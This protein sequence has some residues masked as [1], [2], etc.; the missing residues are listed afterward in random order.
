MSSAI[1]KANSTLSRGPVLIV[2][3]GLIGGSLGFALSKLGLDVYLE[4][5]SPTSLALAQDL[6][7]GKRYQAQLPPPRLVVVATP[8]DVSAQVVCRMLDSFPSAFVC[9]VASVKEPITRAVLATHSQHAH[10]YCPVHPMTGREIN[11]VGA[12]SADLFPGRPWVVVPTGH[13]GAE[14]KL[15][16]RNLGL[17]LDMQVSEMSPQEHDRAVALVS[18]VPQ[19]VSSLLASRLVEA[20]LSALALAGGGLRDTTRIAASDPRLWNAILS[21][22]TPAVRA[23]LE[24]LQADLAALVRSLATNNTSPLGK[25]EISPAWVGAFNRVLERGNEGRSRIP[26]KHGAS[27]ETYGTLSVLIPDTPGA[28]AKLFQDAGHARIN[29]EDLH[30][31]HSLGQ[32]QGLMTLWVVPSQVEPLREH[33]EKQGWQLVTG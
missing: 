25:E 21:Q 3:T 14:T 11:G 17:D 7:A 10:R 19:L 2:G 4:D 15:V 27:Q 26:G 31:E 6:G 13:T 33:L 16:M 20:P 8:P 1:D 30:V 18:H 29:I 5:A 9:E 22:N 23:V 24:D 32:K 28:L 12:A